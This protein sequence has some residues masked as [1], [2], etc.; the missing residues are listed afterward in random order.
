MIV[1]SE[2]RTRSFPS[3][4]AHYEWW[5]C[6][7]L[8]KVHPCFCHI[9]T[10]T[11]WVTLTTAQRSHCDPT[12]HSRHTFCLLARSRLITCE[13]LNLCACPPLWTLPRF[14]LN[15]MC[16]GPGCLCLRST[17][18]LCWKF[19]WSVG[20]IDNGTPH[21]VGFR[22]EVPSSELH[23]NIP[24]LTVWG[25]SWKPLKQQNCLSL[26]ETTTVKYWTDRPL[27]YLRLG[28]E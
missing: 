18:A 17:R 23:F 11:P 12:Y 20:F 22:R 24:L 7:E 27:Q 4:R 3:T 13:A 28:V 14:G 9:M 10:N 6:W 15:T 5:G 19:V 1:T 21:R 25:S 26:H 8:L 2:N 16:P